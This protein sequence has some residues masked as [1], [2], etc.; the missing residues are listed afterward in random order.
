MTVAGECHTAMDCTNVEM[1]LA[2]GEF[3]GCGT[4]FNDPNPACSQ[5]SDCN[6]TDATMICAEPTSR[7]CQCTPH[8]TCKP[9]CTQN[10]ECDE[11]FSCNE[12]HHCVPTP[13]TATGNECP[14]NFHCVS[15]DGISYCYR[16]SC[17]ADDCVSGGHCVNGYCY[18]DY[19]TCTPPAP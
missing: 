14:V 13:C 12:S 7:D 2:P 15:V 4:C 16:Q 5:D 6:A 18:G 19:G 9:G 11:G 1:C 17:T 3:A 8:N 10:S